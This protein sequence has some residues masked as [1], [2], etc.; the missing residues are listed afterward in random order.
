MAAKQ[1]TQLK[2]LIFFQNANFGQMCACIL[3]LPDMHNDELI[4]VN[5]KSLENHLYAF[6][7]F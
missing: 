4:L 1:L 7:R 5:F 2:R 3:C 6:L